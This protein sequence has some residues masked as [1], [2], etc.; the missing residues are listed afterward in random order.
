MEIF[1][2]S[3]TIHVGDTVVM[4]EQIYYEDSLYRTW[5]S[6]YRPKLDSLVVYPKTVYQ[7]V[8]ND[9]IILLR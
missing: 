1:N 6:G 3:D 7:T 2:A 8:T 9:I 5:V 4:R